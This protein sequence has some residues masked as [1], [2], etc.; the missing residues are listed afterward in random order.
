MVVASIALF[1]ALDGPAT[2]ARLIDGK[3]IKPNSI[4]STQIRNSTLV[5]A[6]VRNR[7]LGTVDLSPAAIK[8]LQT[9]PSRSVGPAE[10]TPGAVISEKLGAAAVQQQHI[11]DG[12]VGMSQLGAAA[13]T[14]S[15]IADGAVG[16]AAVA[17]GGLQTRDIGDFAGSMI[18]DFEA[19]K[20]NDCQ[21]AVNEAPQPTA[22]GQGA[23]ISDDVV[24]VSPAA[25]WPDPIIVVANPGALNTLRLI[26]CRI[27]GDPSSGGSPGPPAT[28]DFDDIDPGLTTFQYVAY[29]QP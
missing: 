29:D 25:G 21:V 20:G 27:G 10:L 7:A 24:S 19:F 1:I 2:A 5:S 13:V 6:D 12:A 14:P 15:K 26:A 17:D 16:A 11:A 3:T 4:T 28:G 23:V 9:T 22:A 8:S 18:V